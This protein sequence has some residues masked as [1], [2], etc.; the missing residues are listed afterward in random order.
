MGSPKAKRNQGIP[1]ISSEELF[2][3]LTLHFRFLHS[4]PNVAFSRGTGWRGLCPAQPVTDR[5]V[6]YNPRLFRREVKLLL[7]LTWNGYG[8]E[9]PLWIQVVFSRFINDSD[10]MVLLRFLVG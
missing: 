10:L 2:S 5:T 8:S 1:L 3:G 7:R 4:L 6:G 9:V